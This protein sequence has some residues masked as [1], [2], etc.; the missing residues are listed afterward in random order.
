MSWLFNRFQSAFGIL[1]HGKWYECEQC[2]HAEPYNNNIVALNLRLCSICGGVCKLKS[3]K[4][5]EY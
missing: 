4:D 3:T 1:A 5:I 2:H